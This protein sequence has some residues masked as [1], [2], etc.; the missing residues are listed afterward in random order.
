MLAQIYEVTFGRLPRFKRPD[1][2]DDGEENGVD[3]AEMFKNFGVHVE[4]S[5]IQYNSRKLL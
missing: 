5:M 2:T 4:I 3:F 1:F